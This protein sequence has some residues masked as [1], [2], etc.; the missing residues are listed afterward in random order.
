MAVAYATMDELKT[1]L[2][3]VD[4]GSVYDTA[5]T[6]AL[7]QA[8]RV[9][10]EYLKRAPGAFAVTTA[11]TRYFTGS[12]NAVQWIDEIAEAPT[13]VAVAEN[14]DRTNYIVY[15]DTDYFLWPDNAEAKGEP[16]RRL[17][18]DTISG[19]HLF[20][21]A[22]RRTIKVTAKFGYSTTPPPEIKRAVIILA[23]KYIKRGE[24]GYADTGA[25][26]ELG[27]LTYT[28]SLDPDI[29]TILSAPKFQRPA[30]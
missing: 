11:T 19:T 9:V 23:V 7:E 24:Q 26:N 17:D 21:W 13:E 28:K 3:N 22:G 27:R 14:N 15:E 30:I 4:W 12:G 25:V 8:S 2:V 5:G 1:E 20:W 29:V 10:D 16:Y 18:L 6:V